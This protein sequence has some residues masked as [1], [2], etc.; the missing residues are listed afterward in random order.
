MNINKDIDLDIDM[1]MDMQHDYEHG[2]EHENEHEHEHGQQHG[3]QQGHVHEN[4][5]SHYLH[6]DMLHYMR[7][8]QLSNFFT[9]NRSSKKYFFQ[10]SV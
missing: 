2:P 9:K 6:F 8:A 4:G 7:Q 5:I 1:D 3:H 10:N